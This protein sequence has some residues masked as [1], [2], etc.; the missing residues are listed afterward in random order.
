MLA[1][2][3]PARISSFDQ[4][5]AKGKMPASDSVAIRKVQKVVGIFFRSPPMS[6]TMLK[7][8]PAAWLSEPAP[9]NRQALNM[10]WVKRWNSAAVHAP[11]AEGGDHESE[12]ADGR[13][14]EHLLDV[15]LHEGQQCAEQ[16]GDRAD[17]GQQVDRAARR[18]TAR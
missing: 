17:D 14:R 7:L 12:L 4:K 16:G 5:P 11:D 9:R 18:W 1:P 8:W 10:A 13:V 6:S 3:V 2:P 15:L